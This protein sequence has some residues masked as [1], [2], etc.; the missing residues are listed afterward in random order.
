MR[1]TSIK[2]MK[3]VPGF[4][5]NRFSMLM[6]RSD[7]YRGAWHRDAATVT[8]IKNSIGIRLAVLGPIENADM[9]GLDLTWHFTIRFEGPGSLSAS[10][11]L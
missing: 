3:D 6:W 5:A 11:A 8:T 7:L 9:V 2:C 1:K 4:V 10:L